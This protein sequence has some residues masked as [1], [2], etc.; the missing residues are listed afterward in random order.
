[1][2]RHALLSRLGEHFV[3]SV[4]PS[5][6][7]H[8][9]SPDRSLSPHSPPQSPESLLPPRLLQ[10]GD[11]ELAGHALKQYAKA[12]GNKIFRNSSRIIKTRVW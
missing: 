5:P 12:T 2:S 7:R 10:L 6:H 3:P 4:P 1:M 9:V 8:Y 11:I